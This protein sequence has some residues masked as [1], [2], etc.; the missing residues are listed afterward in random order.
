MY[1]DENR[2]IWEDIRHWFIYGSQK[3]VKRIKDRYIIGEPDPAIPQQKS[4]IKN[5]DPVELL[6]K[7]SKILQCDL[8]RLKNS[9]RVNQFD[10]TKRDIL[11]YLLWQEGKY[12]NI[13]IGVLLGLT[14]SA[15]SRR[16]AITRKKMALEQDFERQIKAIKSQI[17]PWPHF[18]IVALDPPAF[19]LLAIW[20]RDLPL[21]N[22]P[23]IIDRFDRW[24]KRLLSKLNRS[25]NP[26][27][28]FQIPTH[29]TLAK[30]V[31]HGYIGIN[32]HLETLRHLPYRI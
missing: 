1:S 23:Q 16:I 19:W 25:S 28:L 15:V 18:L 12:T 27:F 9:L 30:N 32:T 22:S 29:A 8:E 3:F 26:E 13:Q 10:K 20:Q 21:R 4:I 11:L 6:S 24:S 7:A 2:G 14:H 17:K 5:S 31:S